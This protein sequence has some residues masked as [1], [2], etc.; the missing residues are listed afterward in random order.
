MEGKN[1]NDVSSAESYFVACSDNI[2]DFN[3]V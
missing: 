2:A 1:E 3:K